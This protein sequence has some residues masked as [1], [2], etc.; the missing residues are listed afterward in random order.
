MTLKKLVPSTLFGLALIASSC[1]SQ[2]TPIEITYKPYK[3]ALKEG[4]ER[5]RNST[6]DP[7]ELR[8]L[9]RIHL[10]RRELEEAEEI[11]YKLNGMG[12]IQ[13]AAQA[14]SMCQEYRN[15]N[16]LNEENAALTPP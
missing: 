13:L 12:E 10:G 16:N 8:D 15:D 14:F 2:T 1:S 7:Y 6:N 9:T 4:L 3:L 11:A 5:K